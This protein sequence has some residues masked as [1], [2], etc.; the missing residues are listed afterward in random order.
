MAELPLTVQAMKDGRVHRAPAPPYE[1]ELPLIV[2]S[3]SAA[4][5]MFNKTAAV[6][7]GVT[8]DRAV[9]ERR[10]ALVPQAAAATAELSLIVQ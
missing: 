5:P 9:A 4:E 1:A 6:V 2:Q 7:G 10:R 8:A 3:V